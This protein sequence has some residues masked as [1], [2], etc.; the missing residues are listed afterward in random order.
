MGW[1]PHGM[2]EKGKDVGGVPPNLRKKSVFSKK[3][4]VIR[5]GGAN[6]SERRKGVVTW[7]VGC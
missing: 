6:H 3:W 7:V 2:E 5:A 1:M 4:R